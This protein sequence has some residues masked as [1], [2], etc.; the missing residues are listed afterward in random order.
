MDVQGSVSK[1]SKPE[2]PVT[3]RFQVK[4]RGARLGKEVVQV[5]LSPPSERIAARP[6]QSFVGWKKPSLKPGEIKEDAVCFSRDA[7]GFWDEAKES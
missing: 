5:Y 6:P 1:D 4:N 3:I 7:F 2:E